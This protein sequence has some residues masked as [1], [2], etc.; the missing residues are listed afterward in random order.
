LTVTEVL[1]LIAASRESSAAASWEKDY[2]V[3]A[4]AP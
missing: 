3:G 1:T 4:R 2:T